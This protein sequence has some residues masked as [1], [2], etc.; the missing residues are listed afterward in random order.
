MC[1][2]CDSRIGAG[3]AAFA[4]C[5]DEITLKTAMSGRWHCTQCDD[6]DACERCFFKPEVKAHAANHCFL[7]VP[8]ASG[9]RQLLQDVL[10]PREAC[11]HQYAGLSV[12]RLGHHCG[13]L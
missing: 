5:P 12:G 11:F 3:R 8:L 13:V 1:D 9:H 2:C 7:H 10:L 4:A 6:F